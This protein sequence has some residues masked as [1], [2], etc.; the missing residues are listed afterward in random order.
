M[1]AI[2]YHVMPTETEIL[3]FIHK[4]AFRVTCI[5][6]QPISTHKVVGVLMYY[7]FNK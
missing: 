4:R 6:K 5:Y 2:A 3:M 1:T 7:L